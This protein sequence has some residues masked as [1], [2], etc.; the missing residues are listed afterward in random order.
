MYNDFFDITVGLCNRFTALDPVKVRRY[1]A[2]EVFL[3]MKRVV[4]YDNRHDK[5]SK[6]GNGSQ[7][8]RKKAG[9]DWF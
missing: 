4:D 3:L 2:H 7:V 6:G 1:P 8:V 9:D 5:K